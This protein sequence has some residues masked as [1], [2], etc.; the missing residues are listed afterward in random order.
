MAII[1]GTN[2]TPA[3]GLAYSVAMSRWTSPR[4]ARL[5]TRLVGA[6]FASFGEGST[7]SFGTRILEP[8]RIDVGAR[9]TIPNTTVLDGRGG[10]HIGDDCLLGF[11]NVIITSTHRS[12]S[13]E[14]PIREQGMY[15][16]KVTIGDDVWTGC[17]VVI[18]PGV[19]IGSHAIIGAGSVVTRDLPEWAVCA[20]VPARVIR[21]RRD[22]VPA[23]G[24][25]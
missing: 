12:A 5:R 1:R 25:P 9:S 6:R 7:I 15:E 14:V 22:E 18:V 23:G 11:E 17:R 4:L 3:F 2:V 19:T 24:A 8:A 16:G 21:D 10:L 13:V 20:G